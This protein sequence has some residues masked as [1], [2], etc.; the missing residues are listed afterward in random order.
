M[1]RFVFVKVLPL[2]ALMA[3]SGCFYDPDEDK[4]GKTVPQDTSSSTDACFPGTDAEGLGGAC[5]ADT[6][7]TEGVAELCLKNP[8]DP[9][10]QGTCSVEDCSA[11]CCPMGFTCCDCTGAGFDL[12][13]TVA[14]V[15]EDQAGM[16]DGV[17]TCR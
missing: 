7:C 10:A 17:C 11:G 9:G 12:G 15:P 6:E 4:I 1:P 3:V 2:V 5:D 16:A 14:C 13:W 8:M